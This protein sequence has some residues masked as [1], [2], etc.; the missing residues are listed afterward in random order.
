MCFVQPVSH[1][2]HLEKGSPLKL[3]RGEKN[4]LNSRLVSECIQDKNYV[5]TLKDE[6]RHSRVL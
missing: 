2:D 4:T 3:K 6:R 1:P 5:L